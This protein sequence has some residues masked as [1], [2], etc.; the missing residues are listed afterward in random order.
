VSAVLNLHAGAALTSRSQVLRRSVAL[1][2]L[3]GVLACQ[4]QASTSFDDDNLPSNSGATG[5][6]A[7]STVSAGTGAVSSTGGS[8]GEGS[9][10]AGGKAGEAEGGAGAEGG[11]EAGGT[12]GVGAAGSTDQG[13]KGGAAVA[14][15]GGMAG[16]AGV[17]G[18]PS[19]PEPITLEIADIEDTYVSSCADYSNH[20]DSETLLVDGEKLCTYSALLDPALEKIPSGAVISAATLS[21]TC[22]NS[23][24]AVD[25]S[26]V[27]ETWSENSVRYSTRPA[28]G[29][30]LGSAACEDAG[31]VVIDLKAAVVAWLSGAHA[32][33]GVYLTTEKTDG[34]DFAS[35]EADE[36]ESRPRLSVTYTL[37]PT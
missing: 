33:Y 36:P 8:Q 17:G 1:A 6:T 23:G 34:T 29:A 5:A 2:W 35:S 15:G 7:G 32:G 10:G 18:K 9:S 14:G 25:V 24:G 31:V 16:T 21:L 37:P 22:T 3:F 11:D 30:A 28:R 20:G 26:F 19:E 27:E 4:R 12:A 13:G